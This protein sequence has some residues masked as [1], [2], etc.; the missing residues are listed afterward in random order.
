MDLYCH[1]TAV[2]YFNFIDCFT[3]VKFENHRA[4]CWMLFALG[5]SQHSCIFNGMVF[6]QRKNKP[7][8]WC[9]LINFPYVYAAVSLFFLKI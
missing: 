3:Q 6:Q 7:F 9:Y 2:G 8:S 4:C 1:I 5:T